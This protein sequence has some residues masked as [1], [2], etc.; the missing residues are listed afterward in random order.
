MDRVEVGT[1]VTCT[2]GH[3]ICEVVSPLVVGAS[4]GTWGNCLGNL[5]QA[6]LVIGQLRKDVL[7]C[8]ICGADYLGPGWSFHLE[9]GR[10]A[11]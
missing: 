6:P 10:W 4:V 7:P 5:T 11:P 3:V 9:D 1:K 2:N 8:A